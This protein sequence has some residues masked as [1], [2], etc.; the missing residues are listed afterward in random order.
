MSLLSP[1]SSN[2]SAILEAIHRSQAVIEFDLSGKILAANK[3]F[4]DAM[5]Y[6]PEEIVGRHHSMFVE[7]DY[8]TSSA[9]RDFWS[10][11]GSGKFEQAQYKRVAKG[12][13]EVWIQAS[14]NPIMKGGKAVKVIKFATDITASKLESLDS[15]GKLEALSRAQAIIEFTPDGKILTANKNFLSVMGYD[16]GELTGRHHSMFC[17][18]DYARSPAYRQFWEGLA[19]GKPASSQ[20]TRLAKDGSK[21]FIEASYNPILDDDGKV[22]KVV[23][24]AIDVSG[25]VR[26]VEELAAGLERLADCNIRMTL[27]KPF[28]PE[29]EHLRHNFNTSIGRFQET[30]AEVLTETTELSSEGQSI[31]DAAG[32][33][34]QRTE[35]QATALEQTS[36]ALAQITA[37]VKDSSLRTRETRALVQDARKAASQSV[38]VVDETVAAIGRIENASAEI[39]KI[40][41]VIDQIAF[42]TNLLAL[43]AGV[44]AARAGEA[45]K[46]FAVVAQEVRELAQRSAQ[47]AREIAGLIANSTREVE[48]GVRLVSDTGEALRR[49]EEFVDSINL[50]IEAIATSA[51]EQSTN[52]GEIN[53]SIGELDK[54]TQQNAAMVN[55]TTKISEGLAE[56]ASRLEAL[57]N[58]FKLNRRSAIREPGSAAA[59]AGPAYGRRAA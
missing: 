2:A 12:G 39:G 9:Y 14:Y 20:F 17:E 55:N 24:F 6:K 37:T 18:P 35:Q 13:R 30:L 58:R 50:N 45:G 52:L 42:Q 5:G 8:A 10:R 51:N 32:N 4:C 53:A 7:K 49:I 31:R 27:D 1:F 43:N 19:A 3:N 38:S 26:A 48:E 34:A 47:A 29:F 28:T 36:A 46:G 21:V 56:G 41:D 25:R 57:V 15:K 16:L 54:M 44:E 11:L 23:K 40:I 33:L 22:L 59:A